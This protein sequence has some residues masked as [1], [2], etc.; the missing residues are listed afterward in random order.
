MKVMNVH[1]IHG[2]NF[3]LDGGAM[4]GVVPKTL[5]QR[6][7]PPDE[8]NLCTW[9]MRCLLVESGDRLI[10]IDTGMGDKQD[11]K[12]F[13]HYE[14]HGP[15]N[16]KNSIKR[17]GFSADDITDVF[18]THLH[19]DH[20][21]GA[22]EWV[23]REKKKPALTFKNAQY[24]S[25]R[26]HWSWAETPNPRERASFLPDNLKPIEESG[27]LLF[28]DDHPK[29]FEG[30]FDILYVNGHTEKMMLPVI[31]CKDQKIVYAA[32]LIPSTGHISLPWIMSYDVRPLQTM[33]EKSD[34]LQWAEKG[35]YLLFFEHDPQTECAR[36][37]K[38]EKGIKI[39]SSGMLKDFLQ[40]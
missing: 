38:T 30:L 2:G 35:N 1:V 15:H 11:A 31:Y 7:N 27:Q 4:F 22:V 32:D 10:L 23:D 19:F 37:E 12:F 9:A 39:S 13:S 20:S 5:W 17:A 33:K 40:A 29:A 36:L 25:N 14:P 18:L 28:T 21:G 16:L 8:K 24:W 3:K 26:A 34:L 6:H